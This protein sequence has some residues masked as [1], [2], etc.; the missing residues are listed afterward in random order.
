MEDYNASSSAFGWHFQ[1]NAAIVF[2]LREIRK[3]DSLRIEGIDE[4]IELNLSNGTKIFIQAK[5]KSTLGSDNNALTKLSEGIKTLIHAA[6]KAKYE[7]L[8]FVTNYPNPI[9]GRQNQYNIFMGG[10][11]IERKFEELPSGAKV[12]AITKIA[13]IEK[14]YKLKLDT[15]NL[16][17]SVI[18]FDGDL[19]DIRERVIN[20]Q[21]KEFLNSISVNEGSSKEILEIW[22]SDMFFNASNIDTK[23]EL[24]KKNLM[25]PIVVLNCE[26]NEDDK[27]LDE[28]EEELGLDSEDVE[29]ILRR[30]GNFINKQMEHFDFVMKVISDFKF[31][32]SSKRGSERKKEFFVNQNWENYKDDI[33]S[34]D[35]D[36]ELLETLIKIILLKLLNKQMLV[37]RVI[38]EVSL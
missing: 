11:Y 35:L 28:V 16:F 23:I 4:D 1:I 14:E 26:L 12:S 10:N 33:Y 36:G 6:N 8:Y 30:Y 19:R 22:Q 3:I 2:M 7:K 24:N 38:K 34:G 9:G 29:I 17:I 31:H 20:S 27:L 25:W 37:S 18:P 5:S 32:K 21:I 15:S 13:D